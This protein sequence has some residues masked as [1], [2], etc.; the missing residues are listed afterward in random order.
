MAVAAAA[1]GVSALLPLR[2]EIAIFRGPVALARH[3]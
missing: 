1:P 3:Q 2:E